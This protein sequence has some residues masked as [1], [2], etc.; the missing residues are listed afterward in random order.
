MTR[1]S[2]SEAVSCHGRG[3]PLRVPIRTNCIPIFHF[4]TALS[5]PCCKQSPQNTTSRPHVCI[6]KCSLC[7]IA[8]TLR[9]HTYLTLC[10]RTVSHILKLRTVNEQRNGA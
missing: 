6:L 1:R 7:R 8:I 2:A 4:E 5:L 10:E 9:R 3:I